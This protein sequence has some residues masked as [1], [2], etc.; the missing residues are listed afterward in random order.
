MAAATVWESGLSRLTTAVAPAASAVDVAIPQG[1]IPGG[2]DWEGWAAAAAA[3]QWPCTAAPATPG[4][5][6]LATTVS[7]SLLMQAL[8]MRGVRPQQLISAAPTC[9]NQPQAAAAA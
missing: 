2:Y 7:S 1:H 5:T 8:L 6:P 3:A 9:H 4:S